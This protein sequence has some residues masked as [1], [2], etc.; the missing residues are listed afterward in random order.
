MAKEQPKAKASQAETEN[1]FFTAHKITSGIWSGF[2]LQ[3][4]GFILNSN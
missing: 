3:A 1:S 4:A 2:K